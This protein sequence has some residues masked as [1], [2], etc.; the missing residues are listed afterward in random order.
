MPQYVEL[1]AKGLWTHPNPLGEVPQ[2]A[3]LRADNVVI[4]REGTVET[5]RGVKRYGTVLTLGSSERPNKIFQY[6]E[7]LIIHYATTLAYDSDNAGTWTPYSG[8]YSPPTG[9]Q[10]IRSVEANQNFYFTSS[11]GIKKLDAY[12]GTVTQAGGLKGLDGSG[13]TTGASGFMTNNTQV[14]Y[15]VVFGITDAN[16]NKIVGTPSERIIVT[17]NSG[18]TRDVALN[19]SLPSGIT[20]SHFY[21]IYRSGMSTGVSVEPN[22]ELQLVVEKNP[23]S[24]EVSALEVNY[25]DATPESL[26]G[27]TLYTSPS[28]EGIAQANEPPPL[29]R[30]IAFYKGHVLYAN[31]ISKHRLNITMISVGGSSGVTA[32]VAAS[33]VVQDLTYTADTAGTGGNAITI[34]YTTGGTAGAE[35]VSVVGNAISVQIESGVST[36]T[37][38]KTAVDASGPA[39]ALVNVTV[40]GTGSNAQ[41]APVAATNL[42]GGRNDTTITIAGTVYTGKSSET[43]ASGFFQVTTGGTPAA[44][45]DATAR[46]L[47]KVINRYS[48]NT[49]VYAYYLT[50]YN[51]LPGQILVEER[52]IGGSAFVAT[53]SDGSAFSPTIPSAGSTYTSTNE[54]TK[55]RLYIAKQQRPEAVP[56]LNYLD[57][58]SANADILRVI[59]LRDSVFI[60]KDDGIFRMTGETINDFRGTLFD[61]TTTLIAEETAVAFNNQVFMFSD[62]AVVAISEAGVQIMSRQIEADLLQLTTYTNFSTTAWACGYE[63][64][65]KYILGVVTESGDTYTTQIFVYNALTVSWTR[66]AREMSC[67]LVLG[68]DNKLYMGSDDPDSK[69]IYQERKNFVASDNADEELPVT[70]VSSSGDEVEVTSTT[71]LVVGWQLAQLSGNTVKRSSKILS[72][73][74]ATHITV[75]DEL[76][77]EAGDATAFAPI[78]EMVTYAP[79]HGGIPGIVKHFSYASAMFSNVDFDELTMIFTSDMQVSEDEVVLQPQR[80]GP[81]GLFPWGGVAWGGAQARLQPIPTLVPLEKARCNWLNVTLEHSQALSR[82]ALTGISLT[83]EPMS[84]RRK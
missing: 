17:N 74:D 66:W 46:S 31:T 61:S 50:G 67:G 11:A 35:V 45:I 69:Y 63:S 48:S 4:D 29:A 28:Q 82:F 30:D 5:R 34:A 76:S 65:R 83:F 39:S 78:P 22:D 13:A 73:D 19:F 84:E 77:W 3:F 75:D 26:R 38:I 58:G 25:T 49:L 40:S 16:G 32:A 80:E 44:N 56:L 33:L 6:S 51:D 8:T 21:Q 10:A 7:R 81:W 57:F 43:V 27:A 2:G 18:G 24:G 41:T 1:K 55:N 42:A 15:R 68:R 36:A 79:I 20:T 64:D 23:T 54:A 12:N 70:I 59:A 72:I 71:G 52:G 9:A 62:Q 47:V 53:S 14:A 60:L 37:Q